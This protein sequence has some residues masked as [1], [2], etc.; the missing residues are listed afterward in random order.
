[1]KS[2]ALQNA[3]SLLGSKLIKVFQETYDDHELPEIIA[4]AVKAMRYARRDKGWKN[5]IENDD[6]E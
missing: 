1:M 5:I 2:V 4:E 6:N 3:K